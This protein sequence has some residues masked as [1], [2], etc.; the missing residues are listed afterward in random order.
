MKGQK[1]TRTS[2]NSIVKAMGLVFGDIGTSPIYTLTVIFFLT[3]PTPDNIE[4]IL[5]LIF[6]TLIILVTLEYTF[7]AMSLSSR[8]EGGIIVLKEL[9]TRSLKSGRKAAL[10]TF[11]GYIG[12][13]LLMGDGVI[14]PAISILSAVEGLEL[15]PGI[16]HLHG[17]VI[18]IITIVIT[19]ALFSIQSKGTDKVAASFGPIMVVW[20]LTLFISG[21]FSIV[22][23]PEVLI[24]ISPH[25]AIEFF[26]NN[27]FAGFFVLSEVILCATGG[28]ALYADMGHLGRKPIKKAWYFVFVALVVNYF[29]Q[30][31]FAFEQGGKTN[32]LFGM[33]K[34]QAEFLYIPFLILTLFAT[35]IASQAMI[36]AIFSLV[37]QG[38]RIHIM[39][40]LKVKYTSYKLKS[41]I[42][43]NS[44]NWGLLV[45]V[46]IMI[47]VFRASE[48]LAAAYG[49]A[50]TATMTISAIFIAWIFQRQKKYLKMFLTIIVFFVDIIFL[51][52]VF[53]KVPHGGYASII[54]AAIPFIIIMIWVKGGNAMRK[55]FRP[56]PLDTF[57]VGYNQIYNLKNNIK[58]TAIF[59]TKDLYIVPPYMVHCIIRTGIIYEHN[60]SVSI[61]T[62]DEPFGI[63]KV[64]APD[65]DDGLSGLEIQAGYMEVL[66]LPKLF[67]EEEIHAKAIFYGIE[68]IYAKKLSFKIYS[69]IKKITPNFVQFYA[70]PYNKLH[71]VVTRLDI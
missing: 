61:K 56:L 7:L 1:S 66:D 15:I 36:S 16:G 2:L 49:F 35:I 20:F 42:Y 23:R 62:T 40:L 39:P 6:W 17:N 38:I 10:I 33:I 44:V 26:M 9:L 28:E 31:A 27:G 64:F 52:A 11:L 59:F 41:Q 18:I 5:S 8:G 67:K 19:I 55:S 70:L 37:Y 22:N 43:I 21:L 4:G 68:D 29:G 57:L 53:D 30:G 71:G 25:K 13:S 54:V 58:G 34:S 14:T 3:P 24:S 51:L 12:I 65:I 69:F 46:I 48:N 60:I 50:V 47:L 32:L 45:A 63:K